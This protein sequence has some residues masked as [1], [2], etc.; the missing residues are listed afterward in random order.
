MS[1]DITTQHV[2]AT[3]EWQNCDSVPKLQENG[4]SLEH[5]LFEERQKVEKTKIQAEKYKQ[6]AQ[7]YK[8]LYDETG[9]ECE[10]MKLD[11]DMFEK[12]F[13]ITK[14][15][16]KDLMTQ[17]VK[18]YNEDEQQSPKD[19]MESIVKLCLEASH[20]QLQDENA[21]KIDYDQQRNKGFFHLFNA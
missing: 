17:I 9:I 16:F 7:L 13:D 10:Y 8:R 14:K 3:K 6:K 18:I 11:S 4:I 1:K 20:K 21:I 5:K 15:C 12:Q 19:K 2:E